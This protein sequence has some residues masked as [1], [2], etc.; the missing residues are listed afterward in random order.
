MEDEV[1]EQQ[2]AQA[3]ETAALDAAQA[4]QAK[5]LK[6][7]RKVARRRAAEAAATEEAEAA[8]R[9][10]FLAQMADLEADLDVVAAPLDLGALDGDGLAGALD[11]VDL[12]T[13][14]ERRAEAER[15][16]DAIGGVQSKL[17]RESAA[18]R[19]KAQAAREAADAAE[20]AE[21]A[22]AREA[23][24]GEGATERKGKERDLVSQLEGALGGNESSFATF[25]KASKSF[26]KGKI[27][28]GAYVEF[29]FEL[30]GDSAEALSARLIEVVP[31]KE[32]QRELA[33]A[34]RANA[35]ARAE[36]Q[37]RISDPAIQSDL[38]KVRATAE[39]ATAAARAK[40]EAKEKAAQQKA[41]QRRASKR[42]V[43]PPAGTSKPPASKPRPPPGK[44]RPPPS[45]PPGRPR[46]ATAGG[47][48]T[49][50]KPPM[51]ADDLASL[52]AARHREAREKEAA[53]AEAEALARRQS[54][55]RHRI[56][57]EHIAAQ[58]PEAPLTTGRL[59][60]FLAQ[61][62]GLQIAGSM[63]AKLWLSAAR[64]LVASV[65]GAQ[66]PVY[67]IDCIL[68]SG[69]RFGSVEHRW[70]VQARFSK[71]ADLHVYIKELVKQN[72]TKKE[73]RQLPPFPKK[74]LVGSRKVRPN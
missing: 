31:D 73:A 39:A 19:A 8:Q 37:R 42:A 21:E 4:A 34:L 65:L 14:A 72:M 20:A 49:S 15:A 7:E 35:N 24:E 48:E 62:G 69:E 47:G 67:I 52:A 2:A 41:A 57:A 17:E 43:Q 13:D 58:E 28:A 29:F 53:A 44:P 18:R 26:R 23:A 54:A 60:T 55:A 51:S 9:K 11:A 45:A 46:P 3:A 38:V 64:Y 40:Q 30:F 59:S 25:K 56:L 32:K 12:G 22:A 68:V 33:H 71:V 5:K 6:K 70:E 27:T 61:P 63:G 50:V 16:A 74:K 1:A 36:A 10:Q 66:I